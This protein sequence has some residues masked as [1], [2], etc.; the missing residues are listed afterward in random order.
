MSEPLFAVLMMATLLL[1]ERT[2]AA[3]G[4]G[5]IKWAI[6]CGAAAGFAFLT[7]SIGLT[8][9]VAVTAWALGR[10]R[11][12][13]AIACGATAAAFM[14]A[15]WVWKH[16]VAAADGAIRQAAF[17]QYELDYT[18]WIPGTA[19][20]AIRVFSQ[21]FFRT[22]FANFYFIVRLPE[23]WLREAYT[24]G[25]WLLVLLH[26]SVWGCLLVSL[27][28]Y[29]SSALARVTAGHA[30]LL[31]YFVVVLAWPFEP[32]RMLAPIFPFLIAFQLLGWRQVAKWLGHI[33]FMPTTYPTAA[34]AIALAAGLCLTWLYVANHRALLRF[35][36]QTC[37][38]LAHR[39]DLAAHDRLA[40]Q[41]RMGTHSDAV[42]ATRPASRLY[43]ATGRKAVEP[44]P[45]VDP[46]RYDYSPSRRWRDFCMNRTSE[47]TE[48]MKADAL[49]HLTPAYREV[50]VRY[51][52]ITDHVSPPVAA[53][54]SAHRRAFPD[55]Y[56]PV[57]RPAGGQV[58]AFEI[59]D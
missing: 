9:I 23:S 46:V 57:Y 53:A 38:V 50:G 58:A 32:I 11:W 26:L 21:N 13:A 33:R 24:G 29:V 41:V 59:L 48:R 36:D 17:L 1:C 12:A 3:T 44:M 14:L 5:V 49:K 16:N 30:F 55:R 42:I 25:G 4:R 40:D 27:I 8:L 47:E 54:L 35:E 7:R 43:L 6:L 20:E 28:G 39:F 19:A 45:N 15:T 56:R 52:I 18:T 22:A 2:I 37:H 34:R 10:R 31:A 51:Q